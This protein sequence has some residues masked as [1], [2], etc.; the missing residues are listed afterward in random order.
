M[1]DSAEPT[2]ATNAA[3]VLARAGDPAATRIL[4]RAINNEK[5]NYPLRLSAIE[6]LADIGRPE[7]VGELQRLV[8]TFGDFTSSTGR[9]HYIPELHAESRPVAGLV[10]GIGKDRAPSHGSRRRSPAPRNRFA[11]RRCWLWPTR[12]LELCRRQQ[13]A[14]ND[15]FPSV[16]QAAIA[17]LAAQRHPAAL[18]TIRR[19]LGDQDLGVRLA[20]TAALGRMGGGE[21]KTELRRLAV[22]EGDL[23]R[24]RRFNR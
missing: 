17:M 15:P 5:S 14:A 20:A 2:I 8:D 18:D 16:R 24:P 4:L 12:A 22:K 23:L 13:R 9:E 6:S 19:A 7:I 21:S 11:A 3:I 1:L 10:V